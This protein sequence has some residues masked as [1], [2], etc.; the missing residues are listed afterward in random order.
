MATDFQNQFQ[1]AMREA[2][3][4]DLK[5]QVDDMAQRYS[6]TTIRS[7]DVRTDVERVGKDV[8]KSLVSQPTPTEKAG[9]AGA[10][11]AALR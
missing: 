10:G 4:A 5:K 7:K 8:E 9:R 1:E 6:R 11:G 3:M 2:E